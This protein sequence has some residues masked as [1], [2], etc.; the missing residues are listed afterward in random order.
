TQSALYRVT[1]S[2][3]PPQPAPPTTQELASD[4]HAQQARAT[5]RRLEA[6]LEQPAE[7]NLTALWPH[8]SSADPWIRHAARAALEK[9][10]VAAWRQR[11]LEET[12]FDAA[13]AARIALAR[14]GEEVRWISG[15]LADADQRQRLELLYLAERLLAQTA[16]DPALRQAVLAELRA[17]YPTADA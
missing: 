5:R 7:A 10:P 9:L 15:R 13:L 6:F 12:N 11:A 1:Y 16:S 17:C 4:A 2:G 3:P 8:L 14:R